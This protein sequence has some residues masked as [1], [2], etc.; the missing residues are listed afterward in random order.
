VD[1]PAAVEAMLEASKS[2][3]ETPL[4]RLAQI[5]VVACRQPELLLLPGR[6][7]SGG[8][9]L[10]AVVTGP[11]GNLSQLPAPSGAWIGDNE[12]AL[13]SALWN[14]L[15]H[16]QFRLDPLFAGLKPLAREAEAL[17]RA[18]RLGG[19]APGAADQLWLNRHLLEAAF[20]QATGRACFRR[21][22]SG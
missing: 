9:G 21:L 20:R 16:S 18:S 2:P 13:L 8:A 15:R 17:L 11:P 7:A 10:P 12:D 6:E 14:V 4:R 22:N 1:F 19:Q 3:E 5:L